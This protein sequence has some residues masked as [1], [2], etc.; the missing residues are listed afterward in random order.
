MN[1]TCWYNTTISTGGA[2]RS[3]LTLPKYDKPKTLFEKDLKSIFSDK[4][5]DYCSSL[6]F[7]FN[8]V[9]L[10]FKP[11]YYKNEYAH[12]DLYNENDIAEIGFNFTIFGSSGE[13]CWYE[14]PSHKG[15]V[16]W[17]TNHSPCMMYDVKTLK[18]IEKSTIPTKTLTIV[19]TSVPH[20]INVF[21]ESRWCLSLRGEGP[22]TLWNSAVTYIREK[23]LLIERN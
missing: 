20:S 16:L 9:L 15:I 17:S 14:H 18:L 8:R 5:L 11:A 19:K 10:F 6:G 3:D 12:I 7:N 1:N 21:H 2:F 13:M 4:W 23:G 22:I